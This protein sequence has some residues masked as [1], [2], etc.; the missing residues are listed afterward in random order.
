MTTC[1]TCGVRVS[2]KGYLGGGIVC[3][4]CAEA[5]R[6]GDTETIEQRKAKYGGGDD[7]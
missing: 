4:E 1:D 5:E 3:H 7:A 2:T 6:K